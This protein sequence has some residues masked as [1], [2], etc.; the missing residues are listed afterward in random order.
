MHSEQPRHDPGG[1]D[2]NERADER[3]DRRREKHCIPERHH[4]GRHSSARSTRSSRV[5]APLWLPGAVEAGVG[6]RKM[7]RVVVGRSLV[8][9]HLD[10]LA[11]GVEKEVPGALEQPLATG[12]LSSMRSMVAS[13]PVTCSPAT[14]TRSPT[15]RVRAVVAADCPPSVRSPPCPPPVRRSRSTRTPAG[16]RNTRSSPSPST[17]TRLVRSTGRNV[18]PSYRSI[19]TSGSSD[20]TRRQGGIAVSSPAAR[21]PSTPKLPIW[22]STRHVT[23]SGRSEVVVALGRLERRDHIRLLAGRTGHCTPRRRRRLDLIYHCGH[24]RAR[25]SPR[26][27]CTNT[28]TPDKYYYAK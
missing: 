28:R 14:R 1:H 10:A 25:V 5:Q 9:E 19:R 17:H 26:P 8:D 27:T 18:D 21:T 15:V 24:L 16:T 6:R 2:H 23:S 11:V 13:P 12:G 3:Q 4:P 20:R 7:D 22:L